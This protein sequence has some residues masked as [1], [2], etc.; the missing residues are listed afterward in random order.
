MGR[1]RMLDDSFWV[2]PDLD[3][4]TSEDRLGLIL[5]LTSQQSGIIGVYRV[6][7]RSIGAGIGWTKEQVLNVCAHVHELGGIQFCAQTGWIWVKDWWKHNSLPGAFVGNVKKSAMQ[8]LDAVPEIWRNDVIAWLQKNDKEGALKGLLSPLAPPPSNTTGIGTFSDNTTTESHPV[9]FGQNGSCCGLI[10]D[11]EIHPSLQ[12]NMLKTLVGV[13][14][15]IAQLYL[16]TICEMGEAVGNQL[17]FLTYLVK[18]PDKADVSLG[19][20]RA[21][22][23]AKAEHTKKTVAASAASEPDKDP[24][25]AARGAA[26]FKNAPVDKFKNVA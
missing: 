20:K 5:L 17:G 25:A 19:A 10:F 6:N 12:E 15:Q 4:Y 2:D 24:D 8:E 9:A 18:N 1:K 3:Q 16:D 26:F 22:R 11:A 7:W 21:E 13:D 14:V 23:R